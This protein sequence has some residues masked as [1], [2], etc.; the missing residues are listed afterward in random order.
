MHVPP[1][2]AAHAAADDESTA[3]PAAPDVGVEGT[4]AG[5]STGGGGT[6]VVVGGGT[7]GH[8]AVEAGAAGHAGAVGSVVRTPANDGPGRSVS[9]VMTA[10]A[11]AST[12]ATDQFRYV[13]VVAFR[14]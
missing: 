10:A 2:L 3:L 1:G 7:S 5:V 8:A 11:T 14:R 13:H 9:V 4:T 12:T 6:V